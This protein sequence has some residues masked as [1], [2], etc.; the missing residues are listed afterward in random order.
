MDRLLFHGK[1]LDSMVSTTITI[2]STVRDRLK[3]FRVGTYDDTL[4]H[5]MDQVE[6]QAFLDEM[7]RELDDP[8]T[9]WVTID[10]DDPAWD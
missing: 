6:K 1:Q 7:Q 10:W 4:T 9:Q 3:G 8:G 2:D 5:L